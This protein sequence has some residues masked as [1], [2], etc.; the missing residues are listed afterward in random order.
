[1]RGGWERRW[2]W[3]LGLL[4]MAA[5]LLSACSSGGGSVSSGA[6]SVTG[7]SSGTG[8]GGTGSEAEVQGVV[9]DK[10]G[11]CPTITFKVGGTPVQTSS[12][13]QFEGTSCAA[14]AN[15]NFVEVEG[16]R[17]A[18]G[19]IAAREVEAKAAAVGLVPAA[20]VTV[21][22]VG[23]TTVPQTTNGEGKFEFENVAPG[24]YD[25]K[26][27]VNGGTCT[28]S[29]GISLVA[30]KNEVEGKLGTTSNPAT[31]GSLVLVELEV[32]QGT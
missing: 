31:C 17:L 7:S 15:G 25:L 6:S 2:A 9:S 4:A 8:S 22:L 24:T 14:L 5:L 29:S 16:Q 10:A 20:G 23:P 26:A 13:T 3:G 28:L 32:E 30:Q 21:S 1:M 27:T 19:T 12:S 11:T 18:S